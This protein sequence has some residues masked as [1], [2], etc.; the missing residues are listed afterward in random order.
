MS[1]GLELIPFAIAAGVSAIGHYRA[2]R[3]EQELSG[4]PPYALETR[5]RDEE[6]LVAAAAA[7]DASTTG[8]GGAASVTGVAGVQLSLAKR[9]DGTFEALFPGTAPQE[10]AREALGQL[11]AE[12]TRLVQERVYQQ[13]IERAQDRGLA[14][15]SERVEQDNSIVLTLRVEQAR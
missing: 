15:E 13:V 8:S 11:D 14:L 4:P 7:L 12:Y 3:A 10:Q 9:D 5:M 2:R 6:L 1:T